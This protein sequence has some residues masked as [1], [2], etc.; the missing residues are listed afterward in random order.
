MRL[1]IIGTCHLV[2]LKRVG[3]TNRQTAQYLADYTDL[4]MRHFGDRLASVVPVNEPWCVS[5]LSHYWGHHAP[6]EKNLEATARSMHFVQLGH[7]LSAQ[8]IKSYGHKQLGCVL[9]KE[10]EFPL[11]ILKKQQD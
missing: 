11:M 8:V 1:Y 6:G 7:G 10:F 5:F 9:N 2:M 4:V 3:W